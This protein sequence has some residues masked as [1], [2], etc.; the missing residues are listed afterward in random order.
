MLAVTLIIV[1]LLFPFGESDVSN[2]PERVAEVLADY[3]R[4]MEAKPSAKIARKVL[5]FAIAS[6]QPELVYTV[7]KENIYPW[8]GTGGV[9]AEFIKGSKWYISNNAKEDNVLWLAEGVHKLDLSAQFNEDLAEYYLTIDGHKA[10][11]CGNILFTNW[12]LNEKAREYY[13]SSLSE[14]LAS[15]ILPVQPG[16]TFFGIKYFDSQSP[17]QLVDVPEFK[18]VS[19]YLHLWI[20]CWKGNLDEEFAN[21][22]MQLSP[23]SDP[24]DL[25]RRLWTVALLRDLEE[26]WHNPLGLDVA[27]KLPEVFP[28]LGAEEIEILYSRRDLKSPG[29]NLLLLELLEAR[30][31]IGTMYEREAAAMLINAAG[32]EEAELDKLIIHTDQY[33]AASADVLAMYNRFAQHFAGSFYFQRVEAILGQMAKS[34][35]KLEKSVKLVLDPFKI[36]FSP[37]APAV[38]IGSNTGTKL[39]NLVT[40]NETQYPGYIGAWS[41]S[42]DCFALLKPS[43]SRSIIQIMSPEGKEINQFTLTS[44]LPMEAYGYP[45]IGVKWHSPWELDIIYGEEGYYAGYRESMHRVNIN[46]QSLEEV[47]SR[48]PYCNIP[49]TDLYYQNQNTDLIDAEGEKRGTISFPLGNKYQFQDLVFS[50]RKNALQV[51]IAGTASKVLDDVYE[52]CWVAAPEG[53]ESIYLSVYAKS[54]TLMQISRKDGATQIIRPYQSWCDEVSYTFIQ[55]GCR[56][57][58]TGED[59]YWANFDSHW[60]DNS[61]LWPPGQ[62]RISF[63]SAEGR[64][65]P[66]LFEGGFRIFK[67]GNH[68]ILMVGSGFGNGPQEVSVLKYRLDNP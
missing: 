50:V 12:T 9:E 60:H 41:I 24:L 58:I 28:Q 61:N 13:L 63:I 8:A 7:L 39:F 2:K 23:Q 49:G 1:Y 18:D 30:P 32:Y 48:R 36:E 43:E 16:G 53:S 42:G 25:Y 15:S 47:T 56:N 54:E 62:N 67:I 10:V 51:E 40:F 45:I 46:T 21:S 5:D 65:L 33:S 55:D 68:Y 64:K 11:R 3:R 31:E 38:L 37:T 26:E 4:D 20:T 6:G 14:L 59:Y 34:P 29:Q 44:P 22:L 66:I 27:A 17:L 19:R 52:L 35:F 57:D